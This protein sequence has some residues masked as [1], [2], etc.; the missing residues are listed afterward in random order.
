MCLQYMQGGVCLLTLHRLGC[1]GEAQ[2][3]ETCCRRC[4][5]FLVSVPLCTRLP[6]WLLGMGSL[7]LWENI[8]GPSHTRNQQPPCILLKIKV[9][10]TQFWFSNV[11]F[12]QILKMTFLLFYSL[13]N[14]W[15]IT[16]FCGSLC[17]FYGTI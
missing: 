3:P 11:P 8:N 16:R 7:A 15:T 6:P 1:V 12:S 4:A 13:K 2:L 10:E 5:L 17:F 9:L 14:V